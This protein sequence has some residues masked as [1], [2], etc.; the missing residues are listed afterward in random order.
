MKK[1]HRSKLPFDERNN[2]LNLIIENSV[3]QQKF[4]GL[5][6]SK[7]IQ[8]DL[9]DKIAGKIDSKQITENILKR[10]KKNHV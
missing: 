6:P 9:L 7:E 3:S 5:N 1:N 10:I 8:A 2:L 4:E